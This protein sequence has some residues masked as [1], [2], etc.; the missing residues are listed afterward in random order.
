M[1]NSRHIIAV[2][3][4]VAI[5]TV[6]L[7]LLLI[8][9]FTLPVQASA[10]ALQIDVLFNAH[11]WMIAFLFSLI[12]VIMLYAAIVFRRQEGDEEDGPHIHS[13]TTLEIAWTIIPT[14]VV[15]GFGFWGASI[16]NSITAPKAN[17]MV[18]E[19]IG[20]Q[21]SWTFSYPEYGEASTA[22]MVLAVNQPIRLEM[23]SEDVL[24][25]FWVPEFRIKQDLVPGGD[26]EIMRFTPTIEGNYKL[27]CAEI[28]GFDHTA[29][30]TDV[31]VVSQAQFDAWMD[32]LQDKPDYAAM[33]A[34]ER[35]AI[36]YG[37]DGDGFACAAC[38]SLDGVAGAGPTWLGLYQRE[39]LL[40]SGTT[41]IADDDYIR[42]STLNPNAEITSGFAAN[43]MPPN[44]EERFAAFEADLAADGVEVN[45]VDDLLAY[46]KTIE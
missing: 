38:H 25:S 37:N 21:W 27:R 5:S 44:F 28:C 19:V 43:V 2:T 35:G 20:R 14:F 46:I 13:N 11:F 4:L 17:E 23:D 36:W 15:L 39:E 7:Y 40:D 10:E 3:I 26:P 18:V 41:V 34:E 1:R 29:M 45:I 16:L 22:E 12:M 24:H 32:E 30:V 31:R 6:L 33:T 8:W 9:M 42:K